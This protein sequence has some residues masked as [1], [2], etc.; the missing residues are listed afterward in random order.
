MVPCMSVGIDDIYHV[1]EKSTRHLAGKIFHRYFP[2]PVFLGLGGFPLPRK[3]VHYMGKPI[4][5]GL[6]T[7]QA[8]NMRRIKEIHAHVWSESEKLLKMGLRRRRW[9]GFPRFLPRFFS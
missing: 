8:N 1:C 2:F 3:I 7:S 6:K 9:F 5:H 4:D